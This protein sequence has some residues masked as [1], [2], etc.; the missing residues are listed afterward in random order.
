MSHFR[1]NIYL[2]IKYFLLSFF[3]TKKLAEKR[4]ARI[5]KKYTKKNNTILTSQLRVGFYLLLKYLKK[6]YPEKNE[7]ILNSYNLAEMVNICKSL[8]L[9]I[10]FTKLNENIF[11]SEK[12]LKKKI[13]KKTLAVVAT[14]IFN[15]SHDLKKIKNICKNK[16]IP[17]VEDNAIYFGNYIK[18]NNKKIYSGS[19]GDYSLHSFNIMKYISAM[20]GGSVSTNDKKFIDFSKNEIKNFNRFPILKY[21][22]QCLIYIILKLLSLKLFYKIFFT[23]IKK[24]HKKNYKTL[25]S[26]VYP[27]IKFKKEFIPNNYY[28]KISSPSLKMI[29][30]QLNSKKQFNLNHKLKKENN[31]YYNKLFKKSNI[32][33]VKLIN[34]KESSFQNFNDFPIIV[35]NKRML[36]NYLFT[37]GIETKLIQY[38]DCHKIFKVKNMDS[39]D[40]YEE[41]I[42]C[43][44]NHIK[45]KKSYIFYIVKCINSFYQSN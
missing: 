25:L 10:T 9:K 7:I 32:K 45:I 39:L 31:I 4:I 37:K 19:F 33:G 20:F 41:K 42:L 21:L 29:L 22:K 3:I 43:L 36:L 28:T 35:K 27:S 23:L 18:K 11:I 24:A 40:C 30:L 16:K 2:K 12:D 8:K 26:L 44:P 17:L 15:N 1:I 6:K 14:N 34:I 5:L 38:L 13:N